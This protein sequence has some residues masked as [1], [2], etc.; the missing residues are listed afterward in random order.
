VEGLKIPT[1]T[2]LPQS[3]SDL[4]SKI[5]YYLENPNRRDLIRRRAHHYVKEHDTYTKILPELLQ[6][7]GIA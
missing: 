2:Y 6:V 3:L 4:F 1:A 5:D 7:M